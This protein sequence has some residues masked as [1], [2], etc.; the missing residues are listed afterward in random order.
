MNRTIKQG[1]IFL[2]LLGFVSLLR[3]PYGS[4]KN[5]LLPLL[6]DKLRP[7]RVHVDLSDIRVGFPFNWEISQLK[8]FLPIGPIPLQIFVD[9]ATGRLSFF[10]LFKLN[11]Y[12]DSETKFYG[13]TIQSKL[14]YPLF[15]NLI[16]GKLNTIDFPIESLPLLRGLRIAGK[17]SFNVESDFDKKNL[18]LLSSENTQI[19]LHLA[20]TVYLG[21]SLN[22]IA[23]PVPKITQLDFT[24]KATLNKQKLEIPS[25][26]LNCNLGQATA[27]GSMRLSRSSHI[28]YGHFNIKINFSEEGKKALGGFFAAYAGTDVNHPGADWEIEIELTAGSKPTIKIIPR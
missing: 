2:G 8:L 14:T 25:A 10:S 18:N 28:D 27:N 3:L 13:G 19:N 4:Y 22:I 12:F 7:S 21:D 5:K 16:H 20:D 11:P 6:Q 26:N 24:T 1:I 9:S 15:S 23:F 17:L